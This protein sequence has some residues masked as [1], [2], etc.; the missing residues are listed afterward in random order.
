MRFYST[1]GCLGKQNSLDKP[2]ELV[3]RPLGSYKGLDPR[4]PLV[5]LTPSTV[6]IT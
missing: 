4:S 3:V 5:I 1:P 6:T 2:M